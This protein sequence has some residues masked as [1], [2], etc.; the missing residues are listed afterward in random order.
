MKNKWRCCLSRCIL[1]LPY[2][3]I[4]VCVNVQPK[5]ASGNSWLFWIFPG[6]AVGLRQLSLAYSNAEHPGHIYDLTHFLIGIFW[7][8]T[9]EK[10]QTLP[11]CAGPNF[12]VVER[13]LGN[14]SEIKC[15]HW[16]STSSSISF[17]VS[18]KNQWTIDFPPGHQKSQALDVEVL[19]D[20]AWW[21]RS[22]HDPSPKGPKG[23]N[24]IN[25][26]IWIWMIHGIFLWD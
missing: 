22:S 11:Q 3:Y 16:K 21:D 17:D 24:G 5:L 10:K 26:W 14:R 7:I 6:L 12:W 13:S 4:Y 1:K 20:L 18:D 8:A 2:A 19:P 23:R 9:T 15:G 25:W